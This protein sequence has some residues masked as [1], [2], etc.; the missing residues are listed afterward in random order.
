MSRYPLQTEPQKSRFEAGVTNETGEL[1]SQ[2][3]ELFTQ[4]LFDG[5]D[6]ANFDA[7]VVKPLIAAKAE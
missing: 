1:T 4:F 7:E 2:G 3:Q 5:R 6:V